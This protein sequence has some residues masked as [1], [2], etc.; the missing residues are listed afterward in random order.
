[1]SVS[2]LDLT[3]K[4]ATRSIP[5][6]PTEREREGKEREVFSSFP[7]LKTAF[8]FLSSLL[9]S[10]SLRLTL[11]Q[12]TCRADHLVGRERGERGER[13]RETG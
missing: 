5:V 9:S 2:Q 12:S 10:L 1:M 6:K 4:K 13:V 3:L 7:Y 11:L 8:S